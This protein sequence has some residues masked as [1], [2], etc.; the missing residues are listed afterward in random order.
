[1]VVW[2]IL[3]RVKFGIEDGEKVNTTDSNTVIVGSIPTPIQ[4]IA[5]IEPKITTPTS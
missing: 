4:H 2:R 5:K 1:M 3:H